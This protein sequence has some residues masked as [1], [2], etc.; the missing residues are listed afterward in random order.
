[1]K[2]Y[3][4]EKIKGE[5]CEAPYIV[6]NPIFGKFARTPSIKRCTHFT[7]KEDAIQVLLELC[8]GREYLKSYYK[9][10]EINIP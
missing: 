9:I 2:K 4:I 8:E 5:I 7:T 3:I 6:T 1:M 10:N